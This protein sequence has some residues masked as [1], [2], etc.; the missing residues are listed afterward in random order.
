MAAFILAVVVIAAVLAHTGVPVE[1][2]DL[3]RMPPPLP[4]NVAAYEASGGSVALAH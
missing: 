2:M 4:E 3:D 1:Q